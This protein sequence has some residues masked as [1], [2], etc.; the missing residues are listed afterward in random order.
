MGDHSIRLRPLM[1]EETDSGNFGVP[2]FMSAARAQTTSNP[3]DRVFAFLAILNQFSQS[4]LEIRPDYSKTTESVYTE[5]AAAYLQATRDLSLL[6]YVHHTNET[7][8]LTTPSWVPLWNIDEWENL[9]DVTLTR[10]QYS[11]AHFTL[12][13]G[14]GTPRLGVRAFLFDTIR[15]ASDPLHVKTVEDVAELWQIIL[16]I[17]ES[18]D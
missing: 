16:H 8:E 14:S 7:T 3:L 2:D 18:A 10:E 17:D 11:R 13:Q 12:E 9:Q 4:E 1:W 15:F 5:F 6:Q